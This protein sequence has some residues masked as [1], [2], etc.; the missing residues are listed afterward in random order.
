MLFIVSI[1]FTNLIFRSCDEIVV[2]FDG[3]IYIYTHVL[4]KKFKP[5]VFYAE[6]GHFISKTPCFNPFRSYQQRI[7]VSLLFIS[8]PNLLYG[9]FEWMATLYHRS[10]PALTLMNPMFWKCFPMCHTFIAEVLVTHLRYR[11]RNAKNIFSVTSTARAIQ[12]A[13]KWSQRTMNGQ[14]TF[15]TAYWKSV[16]LRTSL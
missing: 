1:P 8:F 16:R 15:W 13:L 11:N 5:S 7:T 3:A 12:V 10:L 4:I 6:Y 14:S 2:S 9:Q